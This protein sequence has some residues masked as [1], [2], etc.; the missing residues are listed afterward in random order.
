MRRIVAVLVSLAILGTAVPASAGAVSGHVFY[1]TGT[2]PLP[3]GNYAVQRTTVDFGT[4]DLSRAESASAALDLLKKAAE[5]V[6]TP[7][8]FAS[9]EL[10]AKIQKCEKSAIA[11]T[12][13]TLNSPELIRLAGAN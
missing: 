9:S 1:V 13:S 7:P 6:C 4:L 10:R 11:G 2:E 8:G 3:S 12:V 5:R